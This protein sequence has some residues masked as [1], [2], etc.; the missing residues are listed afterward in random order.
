MRRRFGSLWSLLVL[1]LAVTATSLPLKSVAAEVFEPEVLKSVVSVLPLWPGL[2]RGGQPQLQPG[3]APE[4]TA[5]A[6]APGGYLATAHHVVGRALSITVRLPDGREVAAE[7]VGR[8]PPSDLALLKIETDL[9]PLPYGP[10]PALASPVCAVGNQFGLDLSVSCGVVSAVHRAGTGFN[11]IED[12]IQTDAAVNPGSSGGALVDPQGRLV[13]L[14]SAI[15]AKQSDANIGV[16]FAA[17]AALVRRVMEDLMAYGEVRRGRPG[18]GIGPLEA[19][20]KA[21]LSGLRLWGLQ[22]GGAAAAAGLKVGDLVTAIDGRP[23]RKVPEAMGAIHL[24]RPGEVVEIT[25]LRDDQPLTLRLT[26]DP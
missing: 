5:V 1:C 9:P 14:L 26:L 23:V 24:K 20:E 7:L 22:P 25:V 4:G 16:N 21:K 12:F 17:S 3:E 19:E 13:G 11:P 15:F 8:D 2:P 6:I 10:E 18:F